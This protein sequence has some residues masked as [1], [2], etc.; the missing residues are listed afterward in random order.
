MRVAKTNLKNERTSGEITIP[1]LKVYCRAIVIKTACIC[2]ET[3]IMI[4]GIE[5]NTLK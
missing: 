3:D 5:S 1:D 4:N 2:I